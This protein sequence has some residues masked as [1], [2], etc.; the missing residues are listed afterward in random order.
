MS[1]LADRITAAIAA[2][3]SAGHRVEAVTGTTNV[4]RVDGGDAVTG[5]VVLALAIRLGL[6]EAP[7]R[8]R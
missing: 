8:Q 7:G 4:Y 2:L 6:M 5:T 3:R 1:S